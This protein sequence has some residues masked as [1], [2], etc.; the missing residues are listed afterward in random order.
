[1]SSFLTQQ[2]VQDFGTDLIAVSQR[3]ALEV[4]APHLQDLAQQNI[5]LNRR[6]TLEAR[7]RL[8]LEVER[9]LPD[10]RDRDRDPTWHRWLTERDALSGRVRQELLN[11]AIASL[12]P[13]RV[14]A[15]FR[16]FQQSNRG[17]GQ[18]SYQARSMPSGQIYTRPQIAKLYDQH[19]RG[20]Y[21]GREAAWQEQE[22]DI[23][24]AA[25]EGRIAGSAYI[26]K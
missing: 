5:E 10:F 6:L 20:A 8:D 25:R 14:V 7:H 17:A 18:T 24:A 11:D 3:A 23:L 2:D 21:N 26:T 9:L 12:S 4:V 16:T 1:M 13:H 22:R 19:R 15:F